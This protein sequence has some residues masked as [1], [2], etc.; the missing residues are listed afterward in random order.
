MKK[1]YG[2]LSPDD[3]DAATAV[4][5]VHSEHGGKEGGGGGGKKEIFVHNTAIAVS[6]CKRFLAR[7]ERVTFKIGVHGG[8]PCAVDVR[9]E[10]GAALQCAVGAEGG[11]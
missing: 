1:G 10:G 6:G 9:G 2:W 8:R 11:R 7:G 5:D 4:R 3:G